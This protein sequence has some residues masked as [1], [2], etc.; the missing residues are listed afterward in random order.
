MTQLETFWLR[1]RGVRFPLRLGETVLGRSPYCSVVIP[2][3]EVSR[4]HAVVRLTRGGPEIQDLNSANGTQVNGRTVDEPQLLVEGDVI[5]IGS[6]TL[7]LVCSEP[8]G[9]QET[10]QGIFDRES[11][12]KFEAVAPAATKPRKP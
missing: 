1:Y 3:T 8:D 6:A 5:Q 2:D 10:R 7:Q 11:T 4:T 12:K 9:H